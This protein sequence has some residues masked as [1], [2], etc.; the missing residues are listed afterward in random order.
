MYI[1][2]FA[3]KKLPTKVMSFVQINVKLIKITSVRMMKTYSVTPKSVSFE[4]QQS[5]KTSYKIMSEQTIIV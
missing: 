4:V 5:M 1:C 3:M 2:G